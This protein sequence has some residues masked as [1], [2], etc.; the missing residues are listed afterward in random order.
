MCPEGAPAIW[1]LRADAAPETLEVA[2]ADLAMYPVIQI[3]DTLETAASMADSLS[4]PADSV[5]QVNADLRLRVL[6]AAPSAGAEADT[7]FFRS[8]FT[9]DGTP[10]GARVEIAA[11]DAYYL[12]F[13]GEYIEERQAEAGSVLRGRKL[14]PG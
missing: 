9:L 6:A 1:L 7:V 13:N 10:T 8:R 14:R 5:T 3:L 12:F 2:A 4:V 11:D